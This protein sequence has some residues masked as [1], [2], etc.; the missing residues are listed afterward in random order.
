MQPDFAEVK[1]FKFDE[2]AILPARATAGAAGFDLHSLGRYVIGP[3]TDAFFVETGIGIE[4]PLGLVALLRARSSMNKKTGLRVLDGTI[5]SDYRGPIG[6]LVD[7]HTDMIYTVEP[8]Q[9]IAQIVF[10]RVCHP[11]LI[12]V[13]ALGATARGG[14]GFG[15]TGA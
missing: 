13:E 3:Y 11:R 1:V 9:R 15:S 10:E 4:M 8:G 5:D 14:G 12:E 6:V 2:R 7:N